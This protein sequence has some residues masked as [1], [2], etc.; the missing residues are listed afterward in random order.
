LPLFVLEV[1]TTFNAIFVGQGEDH[2][3]L[4]RDALFIK[5]SELHWIR[6]DLTL[7]IG[8]SCA[9]D[10]RIR[11]RQPLVKATVHRIEEGAY[12]EFDSPEKAITPGQFA[13]WYSG[14]ELIGSGTISE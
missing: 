13:A 7:S 10:V 11:Y 1:N 3:G 2:P 4:Y 8:E 6:E 9:Y 5:A 14:E 12:I